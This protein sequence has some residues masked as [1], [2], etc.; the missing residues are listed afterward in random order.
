MCSEH[1]VI[2]ANER[3]P[4]TGKAAIRFIENGIRRGKTAEH[5]TQKENRYLVSQSREGCIAKAYEGFCFIVNELQVCV[6]LYRLPEWFGRKRYY[7]SKAPVRNVKRYAAAH[8]S[9]PIEY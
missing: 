7:D 5:F 1:S 8:P 6:T 3:T 9:L 4:Y 2:R